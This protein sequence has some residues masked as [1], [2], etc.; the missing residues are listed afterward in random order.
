MPRVAR[1]ALLVAGALAA[2]FAVALGAAWLLMPKDWIDR[3]AVQLASKA[4]GA[5][6]RWTRLSH[7]LSGFSLGTRLEGFYVRMPA[8]GEGDPKLEARAKEV[9]VK[10]RLLPLLFRR[11]EVVAA[12]VSGA[13]VALTDR[14]E[15]PSLEEKESPAA[16]GS[17][18]VL[19]PRIELDGIDVRTRD[20]FG[21][22]LD[23][24]AL[25]GTVEIDGKLENPKAVRI[26]AGV[27]SLLWK[28][29][30]GEAAVRLPGPLRVDLG[31]ESK[32]RGKRLE[33]TKGAVTLGPLNGDLKGTVTMPAKQGEQAQLALAL[34]GEPQAIRS[35]DEAFRPLAARTP[36]KWSTDASWEIRI[37]GPATAP[38]QAGR[39]TL[40]PLEVESAKNRFELD[41]VVATWNTRADRTYTARATGGGSGVTL[42]LDAAGSTAPGGRS[43]G[44]LRL[45]APAARLNGLIPNTPM[46][47]SGQIECEASFTLD[48][49]QPVSLRWSVKGRGLSGTLQGFN[50]PVQKLQFDLDGND[51][52]VDIRSLQATVASTT[53]SVTGRVEQGKPLGTGTFQAS[54]DRLVAEEWA[55]PKG[56]KGSASASG[57]AGSATGSM[58]PIPL[59]A[60][61]GDVTIGELRSGTMTVRNVAV[62]VRFEGGDLTAAPIRGAIGTGSLE[63]TL[64]LS[65]LLTSPSYDLDLDVKRAPVQEFMGGLIP[66]RLGIT[67]FVS[68]AV[69][70]ASPGLPGPE[71]SDRLRGSLTGKVE[72][73]KILETPAISGLRKVLG[74]IG[75]SPSGIDLAFKTVTHSLRIEGGRLLLDKVK[76]DVGKDLFE[77]S[78]SM[79]LDQSLN[80]DVI[81]SLAPDRIA[82]TSPLAKLAEFARTSDGRVPVSVKMTGTAKAPKFSV[83]SGKT[84]EAAGSNLQEQLLKRLDDA[85]R[86]RASRR[87]TARVD[88]TPATSAADSARR[89]VARRDSA[90]ADSAREADPVRKALR[91]ILGK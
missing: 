73:G 22:G 19:V 51:R 48:P 86:D 5:T 58:P 67:G 29:S 64:R 65:H 88:T 15:P 59:R 57:T 56:A 81:L 45:S 52:T 47:N 24:R 78:G 7:G 40:K 2:L 30:A 66:V 31:A 42:A 38:V 44:T 25:K 6:V 8:Q 10:F 23:V 50:H 43:S 18:A 13:G 60:F 20:L 80:V 32:D 28:P 70:L 35:T 33:I 1:L 41:Q 76:G 77:L 26:D 91:R 82:G 74:L 17:F 62:P 90:R 46:W 34:T 37:T 71:V 39:V 89:E 54:L 4:S 61:Q 14:G 75:G 63:G 68:S 53:A 85:A 12:R 3:Q 11:V 27:E 9:F 83:K 69:K 49:P 36:A 87:D 84:L 72:E 55:P 79:G 21:S 16:K